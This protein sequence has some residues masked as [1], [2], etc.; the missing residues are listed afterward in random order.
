MVAMLSRIKHPHAIYAFHSS[1]RR[2]L[3]VLTRF[4]SPAVSVN[5][6]PEAVR[7]KKRCNIASV[8]LQR[9]RSFDSRGPAIAPIQEARREGAFVTG[10]PDARFPAHIAER[11]TLN[12]NLP[13][14]RGC[15]QSELVQARFAMREKTNNDSFFATA[16]RTAKKLSQCQKLSQR[17]LRQFELDSRGM[18][19]GRRRSA[20]RKFKESSPPSIPVCHRPSGVD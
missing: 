12:R 17:E 4:Y 5:P 19:A 15:L 20:P 18:N 2:L 11:F 3:I 8:H 16:G 6:A 1:L 14:P 9:Q 10:P 13:A 7:A